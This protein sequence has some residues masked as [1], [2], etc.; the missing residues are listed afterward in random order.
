MLKSGKGQVEAERRE[1]SELHRPVSRARLALDKSLYFCEP[2]FELTSIQLAFLE[3]QLDA[4]CGASCL[5]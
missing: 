1:T 2:H 5:G 4:Q 3:D